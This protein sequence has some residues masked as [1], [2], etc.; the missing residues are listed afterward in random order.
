MRSNFFIFLGFILV[1]FLGFK[2]GCYIHPSK[3]LVA[4]TSIKAKSIVSQLPEGAVKSNN[5]QGGIAKLI[6]TSKV[7]LPP[8]VIYN[9][10]K[11]AVMRESSNKKSNEMGNRWIALVGIPLSAEPGQHVVHIGQESYPFKVKKKKYGTQYLTIVSQEKSALQ[12]TREREQINKLKL[13]KWA[14][15]TSLP[16]ARPV[17][18][19]RCSSAFGLRR[20]Y[21]GKSGEPHAGLDIAVIKGTKVA[22]AAAGKVINTGDY[23]YTGKTVIINHGNGIITLYAHLNKITVTTEQIIK[24]GEQIGTVGRTGRVTGPHLHWAV[25]MNGT[26]IDP[27]LVTDSPCDITGG[28]I[29]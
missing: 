10:N 17:N 3:N 27:L 2:F 12:R 16:L 24:V 20:Y 15:L 26:S 21:N 9:G 8:T 25:F 18:G 1:V 19:G 11:V 4:T 7:D 28:K 22:A 29:A 14:S 23:F 6:F 13:D 5:S